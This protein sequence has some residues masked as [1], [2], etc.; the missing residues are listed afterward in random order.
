METKEP[1][2]NLI[3]IVNR[4]KEDHGMEQR[5]RLI[6]AISDYINITEHSFKTN[7]MNKRAFD[8]FKVRMAIPVAQ[9]FINQLT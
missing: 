4:V 3:G 5:D 6:G 2:D 7:Y 9:N 1:I 8:S